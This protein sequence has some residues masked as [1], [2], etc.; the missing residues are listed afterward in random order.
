MSTM[1][2]ASET[3]LTPKGEATRARIIECAL[4]RFRQHGYDGT[5]M[6]DVA[7]DAGVSLS[8][9]YYYVKSK[10]HLIEAYYEESHRDHV[11][12][13]QAVLD[14]ETDFKTRLHA[15]V[16]AHLRVS[17]PYHRFATQLFRTAADPASPLSPFSDDQKR[18]RDQAIGLFA[19]VIEGSTLK[20]PKALEDELPRLLWLYHMGTLLYWIHDRSDGCAKSFKLIDHTVDIIV[21]LLRVSRLPPLQP[22]IR[23][24]LRLMSDLDPMCVDAPTPPNP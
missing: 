16:A 22:L 6:R 17:E 12:G 4:R 8:H 5:K 24:T 15:A 13:C 21:T 19:R 11:A 1:P 23:R 9:A 7:A 3:T 18:V 2:M 14:R 20:V 10:D